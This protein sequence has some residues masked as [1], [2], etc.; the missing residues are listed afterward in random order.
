[1]FKGYLY[2]IHFNKYNEWG[3][4]T[5]IAINL[6]ATVKVNNKRKRWRRWEGDKI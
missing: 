1:M 2:K 5:F 3:F 6:T 4:L